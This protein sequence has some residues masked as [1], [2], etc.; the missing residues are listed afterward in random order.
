MLN[1]IHNFFQQK[2]LNN[3]HTNDWKRADRSQQIF[4]EKSLLHVISQVF[5]ELWLSKKVL[6]S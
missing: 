6:I 2:T 1:V 4:I 5:S 3:F